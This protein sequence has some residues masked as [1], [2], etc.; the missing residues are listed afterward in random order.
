MGLSLSLGIYKAATLHCISNDS[1]SFLQFA[2]RL[3]TAPGETIQ[4]GYQHPGFPAM[5]LLAE[6]GLHRLSGPLSVHEKIAAGQSVNLLCRT[7]AICFVFAG[8]LNF[9]GRKKAFVMALVVLL[10]PDYADNGSDVLSDWPNL[11]FMSIAFFACVKGLSRPS[12]GWFLLA[13]VASGLAYWIRPE[14]LM[15]VAITAVFG[16]LQILRTSQKGKWL[17]CLG[18][19][20]LAAGVIVAPYMYYMGAIFPKKNVG[21]FSSDPADSVSSPDAG[22]RTVRSPDSLARKRPPQPNRV[23]FSFRDKLLQSAWALPHFVTQSFNT[24]FLL[25]IPLAAIVIRQLA[26]LRRRRKQDQLLALFIG[27]WLLMMIWLYGQAGYM[28]GRHL[29]PMLV[30]A[31][32]WLDQGLLLLALLL[33]KRR[34]QVRRNAVILLVIC[35]VIFIPKLVKPIRPE[36]AVYKQAGRWL[37]E[38]TPRDARLAVFDN[39]IGFYAQRTHHR[40]RQYRKLGCRYLILKPSDQTIK[41][42]SRAS[43]VKTGDPVVDEAMTIYDLRG[44]QD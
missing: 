25:S 28:S 44:H 37:S 31:C 8:F 6:Q 20:I 39:R 1:V 21:T 30:F 40:A 12:P 27:I 34:Q 26:T 42:P 43:V 7:V 10:I 13:G 38:N 22:E 4:S 2:D 33:W 16:V 24:I 11:M 17:A 23:R 18:L 14:G 5:I 36:K 32:A 35:T 19:M 41:I 29:M 3:Q 15:W 9:T